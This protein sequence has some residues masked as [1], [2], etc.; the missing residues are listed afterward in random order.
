V[1]IIWMS[2]DNDKPELPG[3]SIS[4]IETET[5]TAKFDLSLFLEN[6]EHG[7]NGRIEYNTDLFD[8]ETIHRLAGH[9]RTLLEAIAS[10]PQQRIAHL[11]ILTPDERQR[12]LTEW[13]ATSRDYP[14]EL[15]LHEMFERQQ[16]ITPDAIAVVH[17]NERLTYRELNR[18][19]AQLAAYLQGFGVGPETP[20]GIC[21]ERSPDLLVG[22]LGIL[23]AGGVYLPLDPGYPPERLAFMLED[24]QA[25]L[26]LSRERLICHL[27]VTGAH[28]ICLDA[29]NEAIFQ[30]EP[31]PVSLAAP[32]NAAYVIYTSG[33]TGKPKGAMITHRSAVNYLSWCAENYGLDK[34]WGS[35]LTLSVGF[36]ASVTSLFAPLLAGKPVVLPPEKQEVE[37][38]CGAENGSGPYS[39]LKLTPAHLDMLN[40]MPAAGSAATRVRTMIVG[41]EALS[42]KTLSLFRMQAPDTRVVNEYGP[43]E[44]TVGCCKYDVFPDT[45]IGET[46]P[47]GRPIANTKIYVLDRFLQPVPVGVTGELYI[48]GDGLA[49]GY[50]GRADLT[51]ERFIPNPFAAGERMYRT[52]DLA[53]HLPDGNLE[54]LGRGDDQIKLRGF[55][56]ELG[57]IEAALGEHTAVQKAVVTLREDSPGD[58][59]LV[60]YV[61]P[62]P[63]NTNGALTDLRQFLKQ[64]LPD[65]EIPSAFVTV[66]SFP[67]TSNGKVDRKSLPAPIQTADEAPHDDAA[68]LSHEESVLAEIF[69]RLLR[70]NP[71]G[72]HQN[73]FELGG[74]SLLALN[75]IAS[76]REELGVELPLNQVFDAPTV[77]G[78][79]KWIRANGHRSSVRTPELP[80]CL[81]AIQPAGTK[82]P[83]FCANPS[84][85]SSFCYLELALGL[86]DDQPTYGFQSP[87]LLDGVRPLRTIEEIAEH[88][89]GALRAVQPH[90]PYRLGGW[91]FGAT[92]AC[93]M[94]R[95]LE[96]QGEKVAL[97]ALFDGGV[98]DRKAMG[99][100]GRFYDLL[101]FVPGMVKPLIQM[102]FPTSYADVRQFGQLLG[103][104]LPESPGELKRRLRDSQWSYLTKFLGELVHSLRVGLINVRAQRKYKFSSYNG[105]ATLFRTGVDVNSGKKDRLIESVRNFALA[106][107]DVHPVPGNH[108]TLIMDRQIA[109]TLA[110][111]LKECLEEQ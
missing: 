17:G 32:E 36:D 6:T 85:G 76:V 97:L 23:K 20:V 28:V 111:K 75:L 13:N 67:L 66:E 40:R 104:S 54:F 21:L 51:A 5:V 77:A 88:Y 92:V 1:M 80:G 106:G 99:F 11:P 74:H 25:P 3:L 15:C 78:L 61:Q 84:S 43:T 82:P 68:E 69:A 31:A 38:L 65:Y 55:R 107:V 90:G 53:R 56:I 72:P 46:V 58:K 45:P 52:G 57:E 18:R 93:E 8:K 35:A 12:L 109:R 41:G 10:D 24:A 49:R 7:V 9:F 79:A 71:P 62:S 98:I 33:S 14:R 60:A 86:G 39:F 96:R 22:L 47:I 29:E 16:R 103:L 59:R 73:F 2:A 81:M 101:A 110:A 26:L 27:P 30:S 108:M 105:P 64:K 4:P 95:V 91:S 34:G 63:V 42:G 48:G 50:L 83:F 100:G 44:A 94:A 87:G 89:V 70:T 102:K 19:A 37:Y